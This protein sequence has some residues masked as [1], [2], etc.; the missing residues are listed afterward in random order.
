[1]KLTAEKTTRQDPNRTNLYEDADLELLKSREEIA[2]E[3]RNAVNALP[4]DE[5]NQSTVKSNVKTL[6]SRLNKRMKIHCERVSRKAYRKCI[7]ECES[8][9]YSV[10]SV[11]TGIG[12][13]LT[14]ALFGRFHPVTK[15]R[16]VNEVHRRRDRHAESVL[17]DPTAK[18]AR[19]MYDAHM[20]YW[21][22][23]IR[24]YMDLSVDDARMTAMLDSGVE[25]VQWVTQK[26]ERVCSF[27]RE[28]D[29]E[30]FDIDEV[31]DKHPNCRCYLVPTIARR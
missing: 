9:G 5:I 16:Y 6:Y 3:Y 22:R 26:D 23:F 31:P 14:A 30:V 29:G 20:V 10:D 2:A 8:A 28:H 4:F 18:N 21:W 25:L 19:D 27:C 15:V 1:M 12:A 7:K 13:I 24:E 17:A 11:P